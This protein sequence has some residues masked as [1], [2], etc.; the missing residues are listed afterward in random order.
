VLLIDSRAP[1][2]A[3]LPVLKRGKGDRGVTTV[4]GQL[5][6]PREIQPPNSQPAA[7]L[8]EDI[9]IIG[10]QLT[11]ADVIVRFTS[12]RL[13]QLITS[14]PVAQPIELKPIN[15][16]KTGELI[17]HLPNKTEDTSALS[18]WAPGFYNV[19]LV[20]K[21]TDVPAMASNEVA[22]TLAPQISV[23]PRN[24]AAGNINLTLTCEP[25]IITGQR[26]LLIF[27]DRQVAPNSI[28]NPI[29]TTL[30]TTLAFTIPSVDKGSYVVRL[31]VDGVDS[32]PV[33]Y[34][35]KPPLPE[36][37]PLQTVTVA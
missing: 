32:I 22:F 3:P 15:G 9:A 11:T 19:A 2:R 7:R 23:S 37:D 21:K 28:T 4:A 13:T 25:R 24:A 26:I 16:T 6:S 12:S 36:F 14:S 1:V 33:V 5:P 29:D 34:S 20:V 18:R 35:G 17:V 8:G 31:R 27:G 10:E 30:P